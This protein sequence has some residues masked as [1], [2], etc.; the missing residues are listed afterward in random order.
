[1][2][3]STKGGTFSFS[4]SPELLSI[5]KSVGKTIKTLAW[6]LN[7]FFFF[8]LFCGLEFEALISWGKQNESE[9][10]VNTFE[11]KVTSMPEMPFVTVDVNESLKLVQHDF[12]SS[13]DKSF[14]ENFNRAE[15]YVD[16]GEMIIVKRDLG[17][18]WAF[19]HDFK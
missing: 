4:L 19:R 2:L 15:C 7:L 9:K 11:K 5:L 12:M 18:F 3:L 8:F 6:D 17:M 13:F 1:M 10:F 14:N 16:Y